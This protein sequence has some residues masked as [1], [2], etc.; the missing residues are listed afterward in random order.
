MTRQ[1]PGEPAGGRVERLMDST[2]DGFVGMDTN[3]IVTDWNRAAEQMFGY[4]KQE[5]VGRTVSSLIIREQD[6]AAHE[7]GIR[8]FLHTGSA[9]II[10]RPVQVTARHRDGHEFQ[11]DLTIWVQHEQ[12]GVAFY[13]F[14]RD[15]TDRVRAWRTA[16]QLAAIV[17]ASRDA[18]ISTEL[19]GTILTWNPG[20]ERVY[21]YRAAEMI[22]QKFARL[23]PLERSGEVDH[24]IEEVRAGRSVEQLETVRLRADGSTVEV[25]LTISPVRDQ[26]GQVVQIA[27]VG[28]DITAVKATERGLRETS[29]ALARQ[30]AEMEHR[31]FHDPLTGLANR[32]LLHDRI[33]LALARAVRTT[34]PTAL[35]V[36]DVDDFKYV[37][38]TFGNHAGDDVLRE[39]ASRLRSIVRGGD[40]VAR[41]GGDEFA[42]L[43]EQ[44]PDEDARGLAQRIVSAVAGPA[45]IGG[46]RIALHA[47][48]GLAISSGPQLATPEKI[49]SD[50]DLAMRSAK[51][52]GKSCWRPYEPGM[53]HAFSARF[54][55]EAALATALRDAQLAVHYQPICDLPTGSTSCFEALL[56]WNHPTFGSVP[57]AEF[58]PMAEQT[59][60]IVPIGAWVL[61][62]ACNQFAALPGGDDIAVSVNLSVRQLATTGFVDLTTQ[63]LAETGL[64]AHRLTLEITESSIAGPDA[65]V[66][67]QLRQLRAL[68]VDIAVDD[69]GTGHSSLGRLRGLPVTTLKIDKSFID[70]ITDSASPDVVV[71]AVVAMAHGL[72]LRVVAEGVETPA[73]LRQ[74]RDLGCDAVQG[75]LLDKP[76]AATDLEQYLAR[77]SL[78]HGIAH[79][80]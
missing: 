20:A 27:Y 63:V 76:M 19:D 29:A 30:S 51:A 71:S 11:I 14:L 18:M 43:A 58:I 34:A 70:E 62:Q 10:G 31:A 59:G 69:F 7:A 61:R 73:Q 80:L 46:Q 6:Q 5:A 9:R 22:G 53:Q 47:S 28:R 48:V 24:I 13:A 3:G 44:T 77:Q 56:R 4:A 40:T 49:L 8:R 21:G 41:L 74:L 72:G 45:D 35:L 36:I 38:D 64:P 26:S 39:I 25:S 17:M 42:V 65:A 16:G 68:G 57:P 75:F 2:A 54:R 12:D 15:V 55:L 60:L 52:A 1:E 78:G 79:L 50:A 23:A 37:N 33:E 66:T 32:A 67:I